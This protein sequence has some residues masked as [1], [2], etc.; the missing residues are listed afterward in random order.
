M[1]IFITISFFLFSLSLAAQKNT[2]QPTN[3]ILLHTGMHLIARNYGDSIVVR[4]APGNSVA[5]LLTK[6]S[7]FVLKRM[8]FTKSAKNVFTLTDSSSIIIRP[9]SLQQFADQFTLSRDTLTAMAAQLLYGKTMEFENGKAGNSLNAIFDKYSEQQNRFGYA[10]MLADFDPLIANGLGL[11]FVDRNINKSLHYMYAVYPAQ[12]PTQMK[13]DTARILISAADVEATEKFPQVTAV[14]GDRII[15]LFWQRDIQL[16]AYTGY[17]VERS[18]DGKNFRR[19]NRLP[20]VSL[21]KQESGKPIRYSDSV[22]KNYQTYYYRVTGINAFGDRSK[23]SDPIRVMAIDLTAPEPPI[24]TEIKADAS[25]SIHFKWNKN[26]QEPDFKG[27]IVGRSASLKGPFEPIVKDYL[28]FTAKEFTDEHPSVTAPNYYMVAAVDTAGNPGRS[29][30]AYM[31][32]QDNTAPAAPRGLAGNID[33][34]G[35]VTIHWNWNKEEDLAGYKIFFANAP[36]QVFTPLNADFITDTVYTDSITLKTLTKKIYYKVA[37]CDRNMNVSAFSEMLALNKPDIVP[38]MEPII[39]AFNVTDSGIILHW[40][41]SAS[42]DAALQ[43]LLR[44]KDSAAEWELIAQLPVADTSYTDH[45]AEAGHVYSY[46]IQTIDSSGLS[47][48]P[49]FPLR[50]YKYYSGFEGGIQ[51]FDITKGENKEVVLQWSAPS[52]KVSYYILYREKDRAGFRM[53]GTIEGDAE[54]FKEKTSVG[55]YRYAIRAVFENGRQSAL[56]EIKSIDIMND[57]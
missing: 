5:W 31:N 42:E 41:T 52:K 24:I 7:G 13:V 56:S 15:H 18:E 39:H 1:K 35:R 27:F 8:V 55:S 23:P 49:S 51:H 33:S 44:K 53:A 3:D 12:L 45:K 43:K 48:E 11:R 46:S 57:Q 32:V 6:K 47:S 34:A 10:M 4:W 50:V 25:G 9:W 54:N 21:N 37:A 16:H 28:P 17:I 36:D 38:P 14:A 26:F 30:P 2:T 29:N 40:Y 20:F 19:L 22:L